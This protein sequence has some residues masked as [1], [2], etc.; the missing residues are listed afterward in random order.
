MPRAIV[1]LVYRVT[2]KL[3]SVPVLLRRQVARHA[4]RLVLRHE[5]AVLRRQLAG[6]VRYE[7]A[8]RLWF[9]ALSALIPRRRWAQVFP[10]TAG[11]V[12]AWHRRLVARRWDCSKRR[13]R[14][15]RAPTTKQIRPREAP[16]DLQQ[17]KLQLVT[18]LLGP[19]QIR[20]VQRHIQQLRLHAGQLPAPT[21]HRTTADQS[22]SN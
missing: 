5:N 16:A 1:S 7:P 6:P 15:G 12:P 8:D 19:L 18:D 17:P 3:L 21:D 14:P 20:D 11:T 2:G 10:V 4:E 9:A 13:S 22:I